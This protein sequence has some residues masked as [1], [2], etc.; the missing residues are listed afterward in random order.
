MRT[1]LRTLLTAI[2]FL[3]CYHAMAQNSKLVMEEKED[4]LK[5]A[6]N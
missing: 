4:M 3:A 2:T 5:N 6:G 1:Y